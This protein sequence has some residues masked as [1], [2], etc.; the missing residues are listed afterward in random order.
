MTVLS[1]KN[2]I[3]IYSRCSNFLLTLIVHFDMTN[4]VVLDSDAAK[5]YMSQR[6]TI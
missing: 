2:L 5:Q 3:F 1:K 4:I 6:D